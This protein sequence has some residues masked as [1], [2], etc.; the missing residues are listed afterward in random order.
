MSVEEQRA[1]HALLVGP[2]PAPSTTLDLVIRRGRRTRAARVGTSTLAVLLFIGLVGVAITCL[3]TPSE[4]EVANSRLVGE[5]VDWPR[6]PGDGREPSGPQALV[7]RNGVLVYQCGIPQDLGVATQE[8]SGSFRDALRSALAER[9]AHVGYW[10]E[11]PASRYLI[12]IPVS[13]DG[14]GSASVAVSTGDYQGTAAQEAD[15]LMF[16]AGNCLPPKRQ[17]LGDGTTAQLYPAVPDPG[18]IGIVMHALLLR[19]DGQRVL[20]SVRSGDQP[21]LPISEADLA[22]ALTRV[23]SG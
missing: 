3:R 8:T 13:V 11:D 23:A 18:G 2:A 9:G 7:T 17:R 20:V 19:A 15:V 12:D 6:V 16:A 5:Q 22:R 10:G 14:D 1:L 21:A 4:L